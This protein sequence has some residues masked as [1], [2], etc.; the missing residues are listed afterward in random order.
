[1]MSA[2]SSTSA[3][4]ARIDRA[5][6][7]AS[8]APA[9]VG[10]RVRR[11]RVLAANGP[12]RSREPQPS[13]GGQ[14][15]CR[16]DRSPLQ[17]GP[18][19]APARASRH[20]R[21]P[22]RAPAT[23]RR[24]QDAEPAAG[25]DREHQRRRGAEAGRA[26]TAPTMPPASWR[27]IAG[28]RRPE[29]G[30]RRVRRPAETADGQSRR[31]PGVRGDAEQGGR[32]R[33]DEPEVTAIAAAVAGSSPS[34]PRSP[35]SARSATPRPNGSSETTPATIDSPSAPQAASGLIVGAERRRDKGQLDGRDREDQ[36]R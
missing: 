35:T 10:R 30:P 12:T 19:R 15:A 28:W 36:R 23:R 31:E 18:R 17:S 24:M 6:S 22:P 2:G 1:M 4:S 7:G 34:T 20:R 16:R 5:P 11:R 3:T 8:P 29:P 32:Q 13:A 21:R 25:R 33:A 9:V 27:W 26:T 14:H